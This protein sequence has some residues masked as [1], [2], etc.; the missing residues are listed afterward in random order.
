MENS[1]LI[2]GVL[3]LCVL[4][5]R[6]LGGWICSAL[7]GVAALGLCQLTAGLTAALLPMNLFTVL[8]SVVLGLPG[9]IGMLFLNLFWK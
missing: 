6:A 5:R 2:L 1:F 9:L 4:F 7:G 3:A 8:V